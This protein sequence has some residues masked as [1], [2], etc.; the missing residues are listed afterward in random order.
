MTLKPAIV[1]EKEFPTDFTEAKFQSH[2]SAQI[3]S[4]TV[5]E[6]SGIDS[7]IFSLLPLISDHCGGGSECTL[8]FVV[9]APSEAVVSQITMVWAETL[10]LMSVV[11]QTVVNLVDAV[12]QVENVVGEEGASQDFGGLSQLAL[13]QLAVCFPLSLHMTGTLGSMPLDFVNVEHNIPSSPF[14]MDGPIPFDES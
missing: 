8:V 14:V 4:I 9:D 10:P 13:K 7:I 5:F 12:K 2:E 1:T 11:S 6:P 3:G